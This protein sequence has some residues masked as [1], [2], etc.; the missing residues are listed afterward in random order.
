M[1][2]AVIDKEITLYDHE[3][4][5][6][7][8][9]RRLIGFGRYAGIVGT[10]N[11]F[12]AFGFKYELFSLPKAE[13]LAGIN[14]LTGR[15]KRL[16]LPPLKIV[17]T[18]QGKVG[19]GVKEVLDS[20]KVKQVSVENFL[21]K[22]YSSPVYVQLDV[23]D[24]N[25]LTNGDV[26]ESCADFINDPT[27]Y[28]SDFARF[29]NVADIYI[30][31]HFHAGNAPHILTRDMLRD[32]NNKI[33]VVADIS[34]DVAG[35]IACTVRA[36]TITE[37]VYG[38]NPSTDT[39]TDVHHPAA[40]TVMAVDNLPCELPRDASEGFGE[41]FLAHVVPAFYNDDKDGILK[42]AMITQ[43][44]RLTERYSYL[45]DYVKQNEPHL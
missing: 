43:Y 2:Q 38:Y 27:K 1:L 3:T 13:T 41:M 35:P 37:P 26:S 25:R 5:V 23:L 24:Y 16:V 32:K 39:E 44:G 10:Y 36:A 31:G 40:I 29:A 33:K 14:A 11:A 30:A 34:C 42:R 20:M 9:G 17:L 21:S 18:G 4:V 12:R 6:D 8:K 19:M 7:A 45:S 22:I 15:L 28:S